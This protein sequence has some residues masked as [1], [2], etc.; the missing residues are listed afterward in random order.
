MGGHISVM[1]ALG[2]VEGEVLR[3]LEEHGPTT[4]RRLVAELDW[5]AAMVI[6]GVGALI[7]ERLA[8]GIQRGGDWTVRKME[9]R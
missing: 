8:Q 9:V 5:P 6:M 3:C 1:T 4:L 7:R 2:I